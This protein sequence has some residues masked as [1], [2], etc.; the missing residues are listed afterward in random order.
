MKTALYLRVSTEDQAREG[1]SLEVQRETLEA[2]A[3]RE[4]LEVYKVYSDNGISGY[5]SD[6]PALAA[7]MADAKGGKF[8]LV[9]VSKLDR[10]SRNL[11][12]LLHLVDQLSKYEVGFKSAGEPFDTTTS[13]GKLMFQ[14]LGSFAEFERNRIA[15]RVFP[16]MVKGV[17]QGNWQGSR[18]APY[19]YV[20]NKPAKLLEVVESEAEV[21][22]RIFAMYNEGHSTWSIGSTLAKEGLK[23][24][25]GNYFGSKVIGDI[26]RNRIYIGK[27]VWNA[28]HYDKTK[29]T[30]KGY[31]YVKNAPDKII[32]AQGR[33]KP[34]ISEEV[35]AQAQKILAEKG[36]RHRKARSEKYVL[37]G[38]LYCEKCHRKYIGA[39][40][41]SNH[42][43][44]ASKKWYRCTSRSSAYKACGNANAKAEELE[45]QVAELLETMLRNPKIQSQWTNMTLPAPPPTEDEKKARDEVKEKLKANLARQGKLTDAYIENLMSKEVFEEKNRDL[46]KEGEELKKLAA[47]YELR[48]IDR[49]KFA[50]YLAMAR[51]YVSDVAPGQKQLS[52][53]ERKRLLN[54]VFSNI[55]ISGKKLRNAEF[56]APFNYYFFEENKKCRNSKISGPAARRAVRIGRSVSL[57]SD[58]R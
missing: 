37:S 44:G 16:G 7:L 8:G 6:R 18:F 3:K 58:A 47:Y 32:V 57:L 50:D 42:R 27:L 33:H 53:S 39:T 46:M 11:K 38:V 43:T 41:V 26:L 29:K 24:R 36:V 2:F 5:S 20:Y 1:Y 23:N 48:E 54:L 35:F 17:Q 56:F 34:I 49:E 10:F 52:P 45:P 28:H 12:D 25:R 14:Q 9:L 31:K 51:S 22:R 4:G 21:V 40:I 15:E 30:P 19:G 55:K 13:A